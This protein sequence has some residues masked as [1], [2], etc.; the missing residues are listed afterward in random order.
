MRRL[1]LRLRIFPSLLLLVAGSSALL[2]A[3]CVAVKPYQR[4]ELSLRPMDGASE[5]TEDK[6]RQHWTESREGVSGGY[7]AA[8]GGCGCN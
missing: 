8:G 6:F 7:S 1:P 4:E 2:G 3:G 5:K